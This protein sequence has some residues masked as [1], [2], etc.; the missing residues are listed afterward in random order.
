MRRLQTVFVAVVFAVTSVFGCSSGGG[1]SGGTGGT[2]G[3]G[4]AVGTGGKIGTGGAVASGGTIGSGG[5]V[6]DTGSTSDAGD[7]GEIGDGDAGG[8]SA[9]VD[10]GGG[11]DSDDG[12]NSQEIAKVVP[13][14]GCGQDPGQAI[15]IAVRGTIQ[16]MGTKVSG[17]ADSRCGP[18]SYLRE[19]F[20]TLPAGYDRSKAY[21]LIV[22][23][24]GCMGT[25]QMVYPLNNS[26]DNTV[27]R[28]G[29]TPPPD[30]IGHATNPNQGCYDDKEGDDSV[31]WVLY[32]G[33]Y[34]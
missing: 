10:D 13:T 25:G 30:T 18:W 15:G 32:E 29:L 4:G 7:T 5:T 14:A 24:S 16:T 8:N 31:D 2:V 34:D 11:G 9:D 21:P 19:Y 17:C 12:G 26:V 23:G 20:V 3:T 27:I 22:Q 28:V 33:L 1:S 6:V